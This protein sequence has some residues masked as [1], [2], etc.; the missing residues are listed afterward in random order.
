MKMQFNKM[1]KKLELI[2]KRAKIQDS[3]I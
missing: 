2:E 1:T 3:F